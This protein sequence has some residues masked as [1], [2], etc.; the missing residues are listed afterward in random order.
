MIEEK[1]EAIIDRARWERAAMIQQEARQ[2]DGVVEK[3]CETLGAAM[4]SWGF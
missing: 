1:L 3:I 2:E 4:V